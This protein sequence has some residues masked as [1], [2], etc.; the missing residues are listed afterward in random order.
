MLRCFT[1]EMQVATQSFRP[2][3]SEP[4]LSRIAA[5]PVFSTAG[6]QLASSQPTNPL[7]AKRSYNRHC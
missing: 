5:S 6:R 4:K 3:F 1:P 2:Y 7:A